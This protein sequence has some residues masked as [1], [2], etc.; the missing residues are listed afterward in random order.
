[1]FPTHLPSEALWQKEECGMSPKHTGGMIQLIL[2]GNPVGR[3]IGRV[4]DTEEYLLN[5]RVKDKL[6]KTYG[7]GEQTMNHQPQ[8]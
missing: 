7:S 3:H 8:I 1:M 5:H 2:P 4:E 6:L